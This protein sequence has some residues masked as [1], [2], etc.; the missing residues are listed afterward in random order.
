VDVF[1]FETL[2]EEHRRIA[3]AA[4]ERGV[5]LRLLGALAFAL[6]CPG[7][8]TLRAELGRELSDLDYVA[9]S[10]QWDDVVKLLT[11]LGY[12]FDER[13]AMLHGLD[14]TIFFHPSSLRV[15]VFF[16]RLD[17]CHVVDLHDRLAVDPDTIPLADL[18]L[19]KMQIVRLTEKDVIDTFSLMLEHAVTPGDEGISAEYIARRLA[20]DW[21]FFHTFSTN[22]RRV[23]DEFLEAYPQL[24]QDERQTMQQRI[25]QLLGRIE[26]EPKTARWKLRAR[27]G[28][29]VKWYKEVGELVR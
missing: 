28:T 4:E 16:D 29:A 12:E 14:R 25:D 3:A 21:G 11:S 27:I 9:H 18:L 23:R 22:M 5:A 7:Q 6:R 1:P 15:D 24:R 26:A 2:Y 13:R 20:Y 19:E 8:A 10:K 17:M